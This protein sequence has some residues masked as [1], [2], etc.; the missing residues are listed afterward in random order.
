MGNPSHDKMT[1]HQGIEWTEL[2]WNN[3]LNGILKGLQYH[4]E[5]GQV[6]VPEGKENEQS[7]G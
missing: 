6:Y 1:F 2:W 4:E 3:Q 5:L 7:K